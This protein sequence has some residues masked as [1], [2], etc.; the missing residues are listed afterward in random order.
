MMLILR[1]KVKQSYTTASCRR[2]SATF[3]QLP[4][5]GYEN[6]SK[7]PSVHSSK[8]HRLLRRYIEEVGRATLIRPHRAT[9]SAIS[10]VFGFSKEPIES[11]ANRRYRYVCPRT[12]KNRD[13]DVQDMSQDVYL[14]FLLH[15]LV[16]KLVLF[17]LR[18]VSL[19]KST[20]RQVHWSR[21]YLKRKSSRR[22]AKNPVLSTK[23]SSSPQG[24]SRLRCS[25][26]KHP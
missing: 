18:Y 6:A 20:D 23:K 24:N 17:R 2:L 22:N 9:G 16:S 26:G 13:K 25:S 12:W 5:D 14:S 15:S 8:S 3:Q 4:P 7:S 1:K 19:L 21:R 11:F 10:W